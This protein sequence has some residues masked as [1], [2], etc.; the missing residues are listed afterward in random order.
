MIS[1]TENAHFLPCARA[2]ARLVQAVAP[3]R[4]DPFE[5]LL[6]LELMLTQYNRRN[7][8]DQ[9]QAETLPG[10]AVRSMRRVEIE[11][12]RKFRVHARSWG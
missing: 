8:F 7:T 11:S 9:N 6:G 2:L 10:E 4:N 3:L 5:A 12:Q 1:R